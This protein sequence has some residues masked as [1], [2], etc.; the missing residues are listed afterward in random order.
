MM[1]RLMTA[2]PL[3]LVLIGPAWGEVPLHWTMTETTAGR[4]SRTVSY[5]WTKTQDGTGTL[6]CQT[7]HRT[8]TTVVAPT[9]ETLR[10][11]KADGSGTRAEA[12]LGDRDRAGRAPWLQ[13]LNQLTDFVVGRA[14]EF[15][16]SA[17]ADLTDARLKASDLTTF[18]ATKL[19]TEDQVW[20]TG[21][22]A[23]W[24]VRIT[25]DDLRAAFWGADYW[26]RVTDG[27]MVRYEEVRGG[28]GTPVTIGVLTAE[29][30]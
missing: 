28:P 18:K 25:F 24:H 10:W 19:G 1:N 30:R 14:L 26:F 29:E 22:G 20:G 21:S 27:Q 7:P 3:A 8:R 4:E 16:F 11:Q 23:C 9:G 17:F 12:V 5:S 13:D 15:R 6:V 2:L